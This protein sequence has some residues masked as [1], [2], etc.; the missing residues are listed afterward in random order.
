M[1]FCV[2]WLLLIRRRVIMQHSYDYDCYDCCQPLYRWSIYRPWIKL[3]IKYQN[4]Q[5]PPKQCYSF[6]AISPKLLVLST[7]WQVNILACM[8]NNQLTEHSEIIYIK[9]PK[10]S[11]FFFE[12][13]SLSLN[14][15]TVCNLSHKSTKNVGTLT[16]MNLSKK[17]NRCETRQTEPVV[18]FYCL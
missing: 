12:F 15:T 1:V 18:S 14:S 9:N 13:S 4:F 11:L 5:L 8:I 3:C 16:Q 6:E 17:N 10:F 2:E 7:N